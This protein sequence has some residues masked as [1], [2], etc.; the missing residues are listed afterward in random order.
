M[1]TFPQPNVPDLLPTVLLKCTY[2]F[3]TNSNGIPKLFLFPLR[4][5]INSCIAKMLL[6][7]ILLFQEYLHF[8]IIFSSVL[9]SYKWSFFFN[10]GFTP[11]ISL[12]SLSSK[13]LSYT[14]SHL[15]GLGW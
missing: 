4:A 12:Q 7:E 11:K 6:S 3:A 5:F 1:A 9:S 2:G 15:I 14:H 8:S 10:S 13:G